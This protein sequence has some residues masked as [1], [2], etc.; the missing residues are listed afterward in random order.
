MPSPAKNLFQFPMYMKSPGMQGAAG[1]PLA[2]LVDT[3]RKP[4]HEAIRSRPDSPMEKQPMTQ[5]AKPLATVEEL[6][7]PYRRSGGDYEI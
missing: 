4:L 2:G 1:S 7:K 6:L 5:G 3:Q